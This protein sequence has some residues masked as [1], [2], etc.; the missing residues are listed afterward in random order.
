MGGGAFQKKATASIAFQ[1]GSVSI[2]VYFRSIRMARVA[3][4]QGPGGKWKEVM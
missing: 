1:E 3:G 4:A 2:L